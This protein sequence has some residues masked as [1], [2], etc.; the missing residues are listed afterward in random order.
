MIPRFNASPS[1]SMEMLCPHGCCPLPCSSHCALMDAAPC[2]A[3]LT[4]QAC[5]ASTPLQDMEEK[6]KEVTFST[7]IAAL[8]ILRF[9]TDHLPHLPM[10]V[11]SRL[12][13]T[14][15][16]IMAL[17][18]L[19]EHSPWSRQ[20]RGKV[21][22]SHAGCPSCPCVIHTHILTCMSTCIHA[23][24]H[25][26]THAYQHAYT[27]AYSHAHMHTHMRFMAQCMHCAS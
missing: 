8:S 17:L 23:Y 1:S 4:V 15:D 3:A 13:C 5:M 20:C 24:Q 2:P 21:S 18:P 12:L 6:L 11:L 22:I 25:A 9:L 14:N 27:H 26:Y 19:L 16:V 7:A 10:G